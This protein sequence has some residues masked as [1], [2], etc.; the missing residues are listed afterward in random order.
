[1]PSS[2]LP[3]ARKRIA[4]DDDAC[5]EKPPVCTTIN[6]CAT[7]F[8]ASVTT[9]D[10]RRRTATPR[11][12]T[13]PRRMPQP[14]PTGIAMASPSG[15]QPVAAVA[16]M[17][18]T[19]TTHGTDRSICPRR[20]TIIAPVEMTPR[21]EATF[22]CCNRYSGDR[23]LREYR[24]PRSSTSPTQ[25][26]AHV[27]AGSMRRRE[28]AARLRDAV[29]RPDE[30]AS[31][32]QF[33]AVADAQQLQRPEANRRHQHATLEQRLPQRLHVEHEQQIADRAE[34]QRAEDRADCASRTPEQ[35]NS[36]QYNCGD[37]IEC[38]RA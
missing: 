33:E 36:A 25:P 26:N 12:F 37:R 38:V 18:P 32:I 8:T 11:P 6:P 13:S 1:M 30:R 14:T 28:P 9:I 29:S 24:L 2:V 21:K 4:A 7:A 20:I 34:H 16:I 17:P 27:T 23:K 5:G 35:R 10:G 31:A 19:A 22:S 15:P 3:V